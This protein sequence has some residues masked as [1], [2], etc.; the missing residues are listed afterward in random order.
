MYC[1]TNSSYA[2]QYKNDLVK[3]QYPLLKSKY[4]NKSLI[5]ILGTL[6]LIS[7]IINY[8]FYKRAREEKYNLDYKEIL[9]PQE[10]KVFE[11]MN[12]ELSNKEIA[13]KLFVSLSTIK[14]HINNIYSKL[15]ISSRKE[16]GAHYR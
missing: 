2:S 1:S 3:D 16:I 14:T 10:Q 15:S 13:E 11:L 4:N 7:L 9:S 8:I 12:Q 5:Y 6:L